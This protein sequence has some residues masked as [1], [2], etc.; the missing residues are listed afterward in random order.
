MARSKTVKLIDQAVTTGTTTTEPLVTQFCVSCTF[1][2]TKTGNL[3][4]TTIQIQESLDGT[5]WSSVGSAGTL[6]AGTNPQ[7]IHITISNISGKFHRLNLP[8]TGSGNLTVTGFI[9]DNG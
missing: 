1:Q 5:N 6:V 2:I 8:L 9:R 3:A 4:S 7:T